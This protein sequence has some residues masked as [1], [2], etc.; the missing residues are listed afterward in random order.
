MGQ[1]TSPSGNLPTKPQ[2]P[3]EGKVPSE[4]EV[5]K[6]HTNADTDGSEGSLHHS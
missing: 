1:V 5:A 4:K 2:D 6:F 3:V